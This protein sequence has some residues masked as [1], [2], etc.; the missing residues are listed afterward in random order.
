[1]RFLIVRKRYGA[2]KDSG[3]QRE[4]ELM[5]S[6]LFVSVTHGVV[7]SSKHE[8]LREYPKPIIPGGPK[9]QILKTLNLQEPNPLS[10]TAFLNPKAR[11]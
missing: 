5:C 4:I 8:V 7:K 10:P 11:M 9:P 1:M 2:W 3:L 6:V